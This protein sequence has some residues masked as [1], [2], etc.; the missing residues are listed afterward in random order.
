M[1]LDPSYERILWRSI[2]RDTWRRAASGHG[3]FLYDHEGSFHR[4][5]SHIYVKC[6]DEGCWPTN[7]WRV[8]W[9]TLLT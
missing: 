5:A 9:F 1:A 4:K 6:V 7:K 2:Y 3:L 8:V